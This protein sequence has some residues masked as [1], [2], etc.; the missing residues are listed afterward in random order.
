VTQPSQ[1]QSKGRKRGHA[2]HHKQNL[3]TVLG[4][5]LDLA[6][7]QG[8][9]LWQ[10]V[11]K[12]IGH[13]ACNN[14]RQALVVRWD[15]NQLHHLLVT[16]ALKDPV[17]RIDPSA[18]RETSKIGTLEAIRRCLELT[19]RK[20]QHTGRGV[21]TKIESF[22]TD[23][24]R[25][26][27]NLL[28]ELELL[29]RDS[30]AIKL[31]SVSR[32]SGNEKRPNDP[33]WSF[34]IDFSSISSER[35]SDCL[36]LVDQ[37][38]QARWENKVPGSRSAAG[39]NPD[40]LLKA[41]L[42]KWVCDNLEVWRARFEGLDDVK[43]RSIH[44]E[45]NVAIKLAGCPVDQESVEA[46][47]RLLKPEDLKVVISAPGSQML[48]IWEEGGAGK[49][50]LAFHIARWGLAGLLA[51]YALLPVLL[52]PASG[53]GDVVERL[54]SQLRHL[55]DPE[56]SRDFVRDLLRHR[57]LLPIVDHVSELSDQQRQWVS[58]ELPPHLVLLTSR[59]RESCL[60][61]AWSITEIQ[62]LR[63]EGEALFAF[64][65]AYLQAKARKATTGSNPSFLSAEDQM[66]TRDLLER[67]V[68]NKPVTV[69][70]VCLVIDKA[71]DHIAA[72]RI[73]LLPS[74][75]P[76]L[77]LD[78]VG[79][80]FYNISPN[81]RC[82]ADGT[83]LR[84]SLIVDSLKAL[85]LAAHRQNNYAYRPQN[86]GMPLALKA[87]STISSLGDLQASEDQLCE[88]LSYL[89]LNLNL[90]QRRGGSDRNPI[91]RVALDP[92]ADYL[93][94]LAL[95]EELNGGKSP[96]GLDDSS[97]YQQVRNWLDLLDRRLERD[98]A[99]TGP[100]MRGFL[101]AC[102]DAYRD[103]L[104]RAGSSLDLALKRN[105]EDILITFAR[106]SG[107]DPQE[108]R[109]LE[110]RHLIRRHAGDLFWSNP[111]LL[112]KA[113]AELT[114]FAKEFAG[115]K[116]LDQ[117]LLPLART[118]A[119]ATLPEQVRTAAAE[120]LGHIGGA[121]A[122]TALVRMTENVSE[123]CLAV[124][125]AAAEALGLVEDPGDDP[126]AQW[127]LL[128]EILTTDANHLDGDD[129]KVM[130]QKLPLL[131]GAA[132]GLQRLVSRSSRFPLPIWGSGPG[133]KV[134]MLSLTTSAG[135]VTTR[136]VEVPVWQLP[137][138]GGL[139][140]EVVE[141]AGGDY[142]IGSPLGEVGREKYGALNQVKPEEVKRVEVQR[143]V[144][145]P[146]FAMARFPLTQAQW[147]TLA[148]PD[149]QREG[150]RELTLAPAKE[151]GD[152]W[153]VESV[154]W[155]AAC[156]WCDRLQRH[157]RSELGDQAPWVGLPSESLWEIACRANTNTPFHFG[158]TIDATWANYRGTSCYP[159]GR[160]GLFVNH[161][162]AVG[163]YGLVNHWGLADLHGTIW[164]WCADVWHPDPL[165][166]PR[167]GT[168]RMESAVGLEDER[169]LRGGSWFSEP[170]ICRSAYRD[171]YHPGALDGKVGFR[172][173][174]FPS[175]LSS[176]SLSP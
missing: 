38:W 163:A 24:I 44:V 157:L 151:K 90:L 3:L 145:V 55:D 134:P 33:Y 86:F 166:A 133:L 111:E 11:A 18:P 8:E 53:E 142:T 72:G 81:N 149:H 138:P 34:W 46:E 7:D 175:G 20:L 118:M 173:C 75:V 51:D 108:E 74:S 165:S 147:R 62:P 102:R 155:I 88:L 42:D 112:P 120:A 39:S 2:A 113:I 176:W 37:L 52:D 13:Q 169:L 159:G 127:L 132:R 148:G 69:L 123:S 48:L 68:G 94:A 23:Q 14:L 58:R 50:S 17:G 146:S 131:Q 45:L 101:A 63:L 43:T 77:M 25:N 47:P 158:D 15:A 66:R 49:T 114:A 107:I 56:L 164:E 105:W 171:S 16:S 156:A 97:Y 26:A 167:D 80:S 40:H 121:A 122:A 168:P 174:S 116:E 73:E 9:E 124:R 100:L 125:R 91:Y 170:L 57:R 41:K 5:L 71:L 64:F 70:L 82:L 153:P 32:K 83:Q 160:N 60:F 10:S 27:I 103:L 30:S 54:H 144:T 28:A 6:G 31:T 59:R 87:L 128:R 110:A 61:P 84:S 93:A 92:L 78:Y 36:A 129:F 89:H 79:R 76:E 22:E 67:M 29:A 106:M 126:E 136:V 137:L 95:M 104:A 96:T 35:K 154:S 143:K 162:L 4:L 135:A 140:L 139:C 119:K 130:D 98:Q 141:I 152:D 115:G 172:V 117:A 99:D 150:D 21:N 12:T 85:S 19:N 65:E 1:P 161:P 109:K